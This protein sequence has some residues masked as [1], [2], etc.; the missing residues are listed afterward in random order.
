VL[1]VHQL[2]AVTRPS[3]TGDPVAFYEVSATIIPVLF[4]ALLYQARFH[5]VS[6]AVAGPLVRYLVGALGITFGA[7]GEYV[8]LV[9][10]MRGYPIAAD[11]GHVVSALV[12]LGLFAVID[13]IVWAGQGAFDGALA[14]AQGFS[15]AKGFWTPR[16][17]ERGSQLVVAVVAAGLGILF[18]VSSRGV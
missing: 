12:F 2:A 7:V 5:H 10:L 9:V 16:R 6:G 4:L 11:R 17:R 1:F 18:Y 14:I 13:P 8:A 3:R 15:S